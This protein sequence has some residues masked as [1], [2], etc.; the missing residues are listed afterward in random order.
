MNACLNIGMG[1][2]G[3]RSVKPDSELNPLECILKYWDIVATSGL[4]KNKL[5]KY[6]TDVWPQYHVPSL[7]QWPPSGSFDYNFVQNW[8]VWMLDVGKYKEAEYIEIFRKGA[9]G[10]PVPLPCGPKYTQRMANGPGHSN[11]KAKTSPVLDSDNQKEPSCPPPMYPG[12]AI[13]VEESMSSPFTQG[14]APAM[15]PL[16]M[17]PQVTSSAAGQA[18]VTN[19]WVH[20]P[21]SPIDIA[22]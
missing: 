21:W 16:Q 11:D 20:Q 19:L 9:E 1:A 13:P 12:L 18:M 2:S 4:N 15:Y 6:S 7:E 8:R 14:P 3:S 10:Y 17:V 22:K 5:I